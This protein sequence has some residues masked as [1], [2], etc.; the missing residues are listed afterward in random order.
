MV[1]FNITIQHAY[2]SIVTGPCS[3]VSSESDC[4]SWGCEFDPSVAPYFPGDWSWNIFYGHSPPSADSRRAVVSYKQK[5]MLSLPQKNVVKWTD[6]LNM[7]VAVDWDVKPQTK[8]I[9]LLYPIYMGES[10]RIIPEFRISRLTFYGKCFCWQ[11]SINSII[12]FKVQP[13]RVAQSVTCLQQMGV[14]LQIQGSWIQTQPGPILSWRW[15]W[16][17]FYGHSP[18]FR[19]IIQEGLF[20]SYKQKYVHEL[21]VN[22]LFKLAQEEVWLGELTVPPWP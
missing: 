4:W 19:W 13:G 6:R 21:L 2:Q 7:N 12:E 3:A 17:N 8:P 9:H 1:A 16:N 18:P 11:E 10:F 5:C 22:C 15:S 20:V 14:L